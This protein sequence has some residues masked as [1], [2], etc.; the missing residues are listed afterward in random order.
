MQL[1]GPDVPFRAIG[2]AI[3]SIA[4]AAGVL[5][6]LVS[7]ALLAVLLECCFHSACWQPGDQ[8]C[9]QRACW[10]HSFRNHLSAACA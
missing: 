4:D 3:H 6:I 5:H 9:L 10:P 2:H 1:C 8:Q 7:P